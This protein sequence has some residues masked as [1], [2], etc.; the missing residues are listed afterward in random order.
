MPLRHPPTGVR[1]R[2][3]VCHFAP[4]KEVLDA[5]VVSWLWYAK[6]Q[7]LLGPTGFSRMD[8][9]ITKYEIALEIFGMLL[10]FRAASVLRARVGTAH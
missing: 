10:G 9:Q 1:S 5:N 2:Q 7:N 4:D 8:G 3:Q 6:P